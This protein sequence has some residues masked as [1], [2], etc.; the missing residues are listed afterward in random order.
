MGEPALIAE[1]NWL[2]AQ[3]L[4]VGADPERVRRIASQLVDVLLDAQDPRTKRA[5]AMA[6]RVRRA[7][8]AGVSIPALMERFGKS[9][10]QIHRLLGVARLHATD[11]RSNAGMDYPSMDHH[12]ADTRWK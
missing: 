6:E 10:S 8:V 2:T 12:G 5:H 1:L 11:A 7:H 4:A 3:A 9:R